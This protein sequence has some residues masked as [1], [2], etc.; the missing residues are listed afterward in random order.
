MTVTVNGQRRDL[1]GPTTVADLL[2]QLEISQ[3]GVAV[4]INQNIV[5]RARLTEH[6]L[7][8]GDKLEIVTLAGGG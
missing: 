5:P 4:E 6:V 2:R 3:R 7:T 8:D 1:S